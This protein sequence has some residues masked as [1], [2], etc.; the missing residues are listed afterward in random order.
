MTEEN[1]NNN[2]DDSPVI[3]DSSGSTSDVDVLEVFKALESVGF[4][5]ID[6]HET[7]IVY[8]CESGDISYLIPSQ[9]SFA[10]FRYI[11][12]GPLGTALVS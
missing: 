7:D 1:N 3:P 5:F 8:L 10:L 6:Y 2:E 11:I 12:L 4:R 9:E